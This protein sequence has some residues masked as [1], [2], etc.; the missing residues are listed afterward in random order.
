MGKIGLFLCEC[1]P[2]IAEAIDL[3]H[4]TESI[5]K[6]NT[7]F[8]I[9]RHKL[10]CSEDGKKFFAESLKKNEYDRIVIAACSHKQHETTF[11]EKMTEI[12]MNPYLMQ[13]VNIREQCA[14]VTPDK[15]AAT[16]KALTMIRAAISRVKYH[17]NLEKKD[18]EC[19]PA[20]IIV[21]GGIAGLETAL[22]TAGHGHRVYLVEENELGGTIK[23]QRILLPTMQSAQEFLQQKLDAVRNNEYIEIYEHCTIEEILGF[24]GNFVAHVH[25]SDNDVR[26]LRSGA[27]VLALDEQPYIPNE[28]DNVNYGTL[29]NVYTAAEFELQL[30]ENTTTKSGTVPKSVAIIHCVGRE[31]LGY[32]S[33][34]CCVN[35][36]KIA[37]DIKKRLSDTTV[38][39]FYKNLC[40]PDV[41]YEKFYHDTKAQGIQFVRYKT[42]SVTQKDDH[43][44]VNVR[45]P[46]TEDKTYPVDMVILSTGL[47]PS[48]QVKRFAE[49]FNIPIDEYGYLKGEYMILE[50]ISTVNEGVYIT[51]GMYGPGS[52]HDALA[53]AGAAAG[54]IVATLVPGKRL[55][56]ESKTSQVSDTLCIGCGVCVDCCAYSAVKIDE[57]KHIAV[58]NEVL[59]RGCGNCAAACP[60][61]AALHRHFT[62]RQIVHEISQI[63]R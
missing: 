33:K 56:L 11:M 63:L 4:I 35:S 27:V 58:V 19:N 29:D 55:V 30:S 7:V 40:L 32:C 43:L 5:S 25:T 9:E 13:L 41:H 10:L 46:D 51:S 36:M 37:R 50:P 48:S 23:N 3:D 8:K 54:K 53:Q 16:H 44:A 47:A 31:K 42:I 1:G 22:R 14:W 21:G 26:E 59:C 62:N 24:F 18:V 52:M 45:S 6:D 20:A 28:E 34:M 57:S 61:G 12:G 15:E 49:I 60:S 38:T 39:Q 17:Q 2:N